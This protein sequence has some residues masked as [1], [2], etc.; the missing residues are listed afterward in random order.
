M[1]AY[2][3]WNASPAESTVEQLA[4]HLVLTLLFPRRAWMFIPTRREEKQLAYDAALQGMKLCIVQYKRAQRV[5]AN[6]SL[7]VSLDGQQLANLKKK[8]PA[9]SNRYVFVGLCDLASYRDLALTVNAH[10]QLGPANHLYFVDVHALPAG[11]TTLRL[12][13]AS[14]VRPPH[15][16]PVVSRRASPPAPVIGLPALVRSL[17]DCSAGAFLEGENQFLVGN[18]WARTNSGNSSFLYVAPTT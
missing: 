4:N 9:R 5:L 7:G 13:T 8:F 16:V 6:G 17:I 12:T 10:G 1:S 18:D 3:R 11:C 15:V 2:P 14:P